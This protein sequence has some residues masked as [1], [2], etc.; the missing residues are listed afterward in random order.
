[1]QAWYVA[2][3]PSTVMIGKSG[4]TTVIMSSYNAYN[5]GYGAILRVHYFGLAV[6]LLNNGVWKSYVAQL[7]PN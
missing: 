4:Y 5:Q 1:M 7:N 3:K 6:D 2:N